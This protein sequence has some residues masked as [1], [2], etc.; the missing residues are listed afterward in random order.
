MMLCQISLLL[1]LGLMD[2]VCADHPLVEVNTGK[3]VGKS[4]EFSYGDV[5]VN[6][7]LNVFMGIPY[8]EPPVGDLRF[9]PP[10][11]KA[12][13]P[14][15]YNAT[16]IGFAC[17]QTKASNSL[18]EQQSEDCLYLNV[19]S[20]LANS[21]KLPV[22]VWIHGGSF[23][24]GS[25]TNDGLYDGTA[26]AAIGDVIVVSLNYRLFALGF[27]S[28]GDENAPEIMD[29]S[30]TFGGDADRVTVFGE[31]AGAASVDYL[32]LSP[33]S[34]GLFHRV[35]LQSGTAL[36][37][38]GARDNAAMLSSF[39]HGVGQLLGCEEDNS[40]DL[41]QCLRSVP[42]EH[43]REKLDQRFLATIPGI[44][45]DI[46]ALPFEPVVD[47]QFVTTKPD[48]LLSRGR[49]NKTNV[50]ILI[51]TNANEGTPFLAAL[52]P[53]LAVAS[54]PTVSKAE[55]GQVY[56]LLLYG[57]FKHNPTA[58]DAIKLMYIPWSDVAANDTN[59]A[60]AYIEMQSD[61]MFVCPADKSARAYSNSGANVYMYHMTHAPANPL[62]RIQWAKAGHA[63][64]LPFVFG[65]HFNALPYWPLAPEEVNMSLSIIT[66]WTN[67]AKTG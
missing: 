22:M 39:A 20:P 19:Y 10:Q 36:L 12:P 41:V 47:G 30:I 17:I 9:R 67:M 55:Y 60:D 43:F 34:D 11:P 31:S 51:G 21:T 38:S 50:D 66:Y 65:T 13:W 62:S 58:Q 5:N 1:V 59:Y 18:Q 14:G 63:E 15:I 44:Q 49:F 61:Y 35:I 8:A 45:T 28:T 52:L 26:L 6:R 54:E 32:L 33:M 46:I 4:V 2:Y 53:S 40:E 25:A 42:A 57:S 56:L 37:A 27:F 24:R 3:L 23:S 48:D 64:D 7:T 16:D 29:C